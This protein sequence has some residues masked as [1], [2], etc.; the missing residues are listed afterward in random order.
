MNNKHGSL[1]SVPWPQSELIFCLVLTP[2]AALWAPCL[3]AGKPAGTCAG[4]AHIDI[5][6]L[7]ML[8]KVSFSED[9]LSGCTILGSCKQKKNGA[10]M[11]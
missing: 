4:N 9:P 5:Q 6:Q 1:I 10:A 11:G 8:L 7:D 3:K 2:A